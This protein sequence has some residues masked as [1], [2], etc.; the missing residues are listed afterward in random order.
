MSTPDLLFKILNSYYK[1]KKSLVMQYGDGHYTPEEFARL[2]LSEFENSRT[3]LIAAM[4]GELI[5]GMAPIPSDLDFA[6][7]ILESF[8]VLD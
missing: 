3:E 8:T 2:M 1:K 6:G 5:N 7:K 4:Y